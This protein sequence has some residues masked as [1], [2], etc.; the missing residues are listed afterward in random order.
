[1]ARLIVVAVVA[2]FVAMPVRADTTYS[3][4][5]FSKQ[6]IVS[7]SRAALE[8]APSWKDDADNPP[9]S[10]KKAIKLANEMKDSLVKDTEDFKWK[11]ESAALKPAGD[12]KWYWLVHYDAVFQS[13][14]TGQPN[15]LRLVVLMDGTVIKPVIKDD[16]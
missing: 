7:I 16:P 5:A 14:P 3:S 13:A 12:G 2:V 11:L 10:A 15:H 8:K 6:Y 9:L 1:M 4:Y